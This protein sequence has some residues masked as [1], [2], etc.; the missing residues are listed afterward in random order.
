[1]S[2]K[3]KKSSSSLSFS[4]SRWFRR[5]STGTPTITVAAIAGLAYSIF[6]F[7]GGLFTLINHPQPS[8]Y[9]NGK[10]YF[11]YPGIS[12]QFI[13]DTLISVI[14]YALGFVGLLMIYQSTKSAYKPRQAY[15]M[16]V[17]GVAFLFLSYLF[18]EGCISFKVNNGQ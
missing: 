10:F 12:S 18:L 16:L 17:I 7:G 2:S 5:I 1:M 9:Y 14:L 15:M 8:A 6:M 3:V 11:L 13:S 4:L